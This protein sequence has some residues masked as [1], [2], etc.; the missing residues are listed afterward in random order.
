MKF[1]FPDSQDLVDP[2]FD[3]DMETRSAT[4]LRQRDDLY[5]HEIFSPPPFD[6]ILV[7]KAIVDGCGSGG[8]YS[9]AQRH[10]L[11]REGVRRFF[12][13]DKIDSKV[14][15]DT[16]GDCGAF[17]YVREDRPPFSVESV[18]DFYVDCGFDYGVSV[19][20][21]I[22]I[23]KPDVEDSAQNNLFLKSDL[24]L[25]PPDIV[26]RH[27]LTLELAE[28]FM[29]LHKKRRCKFTPVGVAQGWTPWSYARSVVALQKL[30]YT[31]IAIGGLVPLKTH[32]ILAVMERVS[33]VRKPNTEF[34]LFGVTRTSE[35]DNFIRFGATSF[36]STSP[37]RQ[38][39][40]DDKDNFYTLDRTYVAV[41]VPQVQGNAS[42]QRKIRAG[43]IPGDEARRLEQASLEVLKRF[44]RGEATVE[45]A[46]D[47]VLEYE[48]LHSPGKRDHEAVYRETLTDRPWKDC[49]CE[50]CR[51]VGIHVILFRGAERNR[52]RGFHNIHVFNRRL[53]IQLAAADQSPAAQGALTA[54]R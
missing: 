9:I 43:Q 10:R 37:L 2:S 20:H 52:R 6:G 32:E 46:L 1:F 17:S 31:K 14:R 3:F 49:P 19:D 30:G 42:L 7:S 16:M 47:V 23:Y 18:I 25:V 5:A 28:E 4:R 44:D 45:E 15:L 38:A 33:S 41:R 27:A 29:T 50:I 39:F 13:L 24:D 8:R 48:R 26:E 35:V 11:L 12:R 34:H 21:I 53:K 22:P 36:D 54:A 40:K 51:A